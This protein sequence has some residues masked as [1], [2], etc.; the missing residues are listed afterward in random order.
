MPIQFLTASAT[1]IGFSDF[2]AI[3]T[4]LTAQIN[5]ASI[6]SVL[7]GVLAACVGMV[8]MWW[9]VRK[10]ARMVMSAFQKGKVSL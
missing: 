5:V 9:G 2:E 1:P 6:V 7:G 4:G 3:F 8:F 10:I